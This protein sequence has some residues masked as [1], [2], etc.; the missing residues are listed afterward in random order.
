MTH[1]RIIA[2][3]SLDNRGGLKV[4]LVP[5][6]DHLLK[7]GKFIIE[8]SKVVVTAFNA[9]AVRV[10]GVRTTVFVISEESKVLGPVAQRG[11]S[12]VE[13]VR[14]SDVVCSGVALKQKAVLVIVGVPPHLVICQ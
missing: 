7:I 13:L 2:L 10:E 11:Y 1:E 9:I 3:I 12:L 8:A 4:E 6:I 14:A 5:A